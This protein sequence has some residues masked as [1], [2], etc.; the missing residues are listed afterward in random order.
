M[1][2][3][4]ELEAVVAEQL[5]HSFA[6]DPYDAQQYAKAAVFVFRSTYSGGFK[7]SP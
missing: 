4:T 6:L 2:N 7:Q 5:V 1:T 3:Q